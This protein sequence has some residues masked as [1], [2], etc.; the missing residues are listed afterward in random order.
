MSS[1]IATESEELPRNIPSDSSSVLTDIEIT[2]PKDDKSSSSGDEELLRKFREQQANRRLRPTSAKV[3]YKK[4]VDP[5]PETV[6]T[7]HTRDSDRE[8]NVSWSSTVF[9]SSESSNFAP[10]KSHVEQRQSNSSSSNST[11]QQQKSQRSRSSSSDGSTDVNE[12]SRPRKHRKSATSKSSNSSSTSNDRPIP[13]QQSGVKPKSDFFKES[14]H[15]RKSSD[16]QKFKPKVRP[17]QLEERPPSRQGRR[18]DPPQS[19]RVGRTRTRS[20]PG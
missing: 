14:K 6:K 15:K 11:L 18:R 3:K 2:S 12:K 9:S 19:K 10:R 7:Y 5:E 13:V 20:K 17:P 1:S 16:S 8:D 4:V